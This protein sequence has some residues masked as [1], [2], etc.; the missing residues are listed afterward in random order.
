MGGWRANRHL[1]GNFIRFMVYSM[2]YD[3]D[4]IL[5]IRVQFATP[6]ANALGQFVLVF[7]DTPE[8]VHHRLL[9]VSSSLFILHL[10]A[11]GV[12]REFNLQ[13]WFTLAKIYTKD[14]GSI[15]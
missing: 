4:G 11:F 8:F 7:H 14:Q 1:F 12:Y 6:Q 5:G 3:L 13:V 10:M 2:E 9:V 15:P